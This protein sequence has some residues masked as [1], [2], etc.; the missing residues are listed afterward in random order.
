MSND[1]SIMHQ[2]VVGKRGKSGPFS[3]HV[4]LSGVTQEMANDGSSMRGSV[5]SPENRQRGWKTADMN[6]ALANDAQWVYYENLNL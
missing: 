4:K 3:P 1:G 2:P 5:R 6:E